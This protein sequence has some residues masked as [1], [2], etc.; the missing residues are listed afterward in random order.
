M[1]KMTVS[2]PLV[3]AS[4]ARITPQAQVGLHVRVHSTGTRINVNGALGQFIHTLVQKQPLASRQPRRG[5]R[6]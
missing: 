6:A 5:C 3:Q 4:L 2:A 1:Y